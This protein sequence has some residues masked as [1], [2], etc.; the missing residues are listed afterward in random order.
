[1]GGKGLRCH[2]NLHHCN[3][4]DGEKRGGVWNG[5]CALV[6]EGRGPECSTWVC[7]ELRKV[8]TGLFR[9]HILSQPAVLKMIHSAATV[10]LKLAKQKDNT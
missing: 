1:M 6:E 4:S 8:S 9:K 3:Y 10:S 2:G 7:L 5:V